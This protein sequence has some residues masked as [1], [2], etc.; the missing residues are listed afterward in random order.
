MMQ[1]H[2]LDNPVDR[3][4]GDVVAAIYF[5]ED[6]PL[7]GPAALLDWRLNGRLT[8]QLLQGSLDGSIGEQLLVQSN[9]KIAADWALL[10][11]GGSRA[12]LDESG[13]RNLLRRLLSTCHRAGASRVALGLGIP[14]G[15][16]S[17]GLQRLVRLTLDEMA[18]ANLDCLLGIVDDGARLV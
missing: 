12:G 2:L 1:L 5:V 14:A 10:A 16:T 3:F 17:A 15:M 18:P 4:E 8:E 7:C 9:G 13:Y 6:R 11:G